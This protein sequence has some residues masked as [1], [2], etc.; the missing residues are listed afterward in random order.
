MTSPAEQLLGADC[1]TTAQTADEFNALEVIVKKTEQ[2]GLEPKVLRKLRD[3]AE[4][5]LVTKFDMLCTKQGTHRNTR[6]CTI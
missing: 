5:P 3:A 4:A 6:M 2:G 1:V